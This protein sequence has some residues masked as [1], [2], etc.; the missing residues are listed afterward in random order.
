MFFIV[1][2]LNSSQTESLSWP[3]I[4][5]NGFHAR[6]ERLAGVLRGGGGRG[7]AFTSTFGGRGAEK[8]PSIVR[9]SVE[10]D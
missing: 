3:E 4:V 7:E 8:K 5:I 9:R 10:L 6:P 1:R 2:S